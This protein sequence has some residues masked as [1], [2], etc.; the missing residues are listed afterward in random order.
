MEETNTNLNNI[1]NETVQEKENEETLENIQDDT[2][3]DSTEDTNEKDNSNK[4]FLNDN[5]SQVSKEFN[6]TEN[7]NEIKTQICSILYIAKKYIAVDF[8][9]FGIQVDLDG[10]K[11]DENAKEIEV[12]YQSEI[13]KADFK[14]WVGKNN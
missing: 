11:I 10:I 12:Q 8:K 4:K 14:F 6:V 7:K 9:G 2:I 5:D 13:G 1:I 3:L